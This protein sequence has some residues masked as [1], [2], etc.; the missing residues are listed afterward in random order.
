MCLHVANLGQGQIESNTTCSE[1]LLQG[2]VCISQDVMVLLVHVRE[3]IK[4]AW[5]EFRNILQYCV[6]KASF[7]D[8]VGL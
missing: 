2:Q 7:V 5:V 3:R 8:L 4:F 1:E 6:Y